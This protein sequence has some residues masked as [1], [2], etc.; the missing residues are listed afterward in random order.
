[1]IE[2]K[3]ANA[4]VDEDSFHKV[5]REYLLVLRF[6]VLDTGRDPSFNANHLLSYL[7]DDFIQSAAAITFLAREGGLSVAKRE[8]RFLIESSIKLCFV[9][10]QKYNSTVQEKLAE[11]DEELSSPSISIKRDLNLNMLPSDLRTV[12]SEEIGRLYGKMSGYVHLT[13]NQILERIAA[14]DAGMSLGREGSPQVQELTNLISKGFAASL[15]LLLHSVPEY[16]AGD[17]LVAQDGSTIDSYFVGS[18]FVAA[19]DSY[20]DYKHE[21]KASLTAI[22]AARASKIAF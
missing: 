18:R 21:R 3:S 17:L 19:I 15:V 11:F 12:F 16:V 1:M 7:A 20:F 13:P 22:Q 5:L 8:L 6:I 9:H 14:I 10:Q 4:Q 2:N